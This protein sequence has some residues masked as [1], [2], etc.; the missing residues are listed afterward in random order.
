MITE[1]LMN[2]MQNIFGNIEVA[3][4]VIRRKKKEYPNF[5]KQIEDSFIHMKPR[6]TFSSNFI[7]E[8][9]CECMIERIINN[10]DIFEPTDAELLQAFSDTSLRAPLTSD[11]AQVYK[12]LFD[13]FFPKE[14]KEI[15]DVGY[16]WK[17]RNEEILNKL[18]RNLRKRF[19][20]ESK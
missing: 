9:H 4:K 12:L 3:E 6:I 10:L 15:G 18:K 16:S 5:A 8:K 2:T 11:Y 17:G 20:E 13:K 7:Y 19:R 14:G 1:N